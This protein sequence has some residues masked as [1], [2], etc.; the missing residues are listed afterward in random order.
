MKC[1][2]C[3]SRE[4]KVAIKKKIDGKECELFVCDVCAKSKKTKVKSVS[5]DAND[6]EQ[7][8]AFMEFLSSLQKGDAPD[9]LKNAFGKLFKDEEL[10]YKMIHNPTAQDKRVLVCSDCGMDF[11][12][13]KMT[14]LLSCPNCYKTFSKE[15]KPIIRKSNPG[16]QHVGLT[17]FRFLKGK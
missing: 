15:L 14:G 17:P 1:E 11:E 2:I 5:I 6:P 9:V 12:K 10:T 13:Y 7:A 8:K 4:A 3:H 16:E